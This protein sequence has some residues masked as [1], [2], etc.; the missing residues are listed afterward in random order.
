[1]FNYSEEFTCKVLK[2]YEHW[3]Q[4]IYKIPNNHVIYQNHLCIWFLRTTQPRDWT[5]NYQ[6]IR[7][8]LTNT[9]IHKD[10]YLLVI[11]SSSVGE[12][13]SDTKVNKIRSINWYDL[14]PLHTES[15]MRMFHS[16]GLNK[17]VHWKFPKVTKYNKQLKKAEEHN[18]RNVVSIA[19]KMRM[20]IW[21]ERHIMIIPHKKF[22]YKTFFRYKKIIVY[23]FIEDILK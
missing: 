11:Y 2:L 5:H 16:C 12:K 21:M 9:L 14:S 6:G 20:L 13:K 7:F 23:S 17:G 3:S 19:T 10:M 1:M 22:Q 18:G 4:S 8:V 15:R